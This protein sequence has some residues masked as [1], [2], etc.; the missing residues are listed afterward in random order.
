M[1]QQSSYNA[2]YDESNGLV[3]EG[4]YVAG[5]DANI[6]YYFNVNGGLYQ[7]IYQFTHDHANE[8]EFIRDYEEIREQL[9]EKYGEPSEDEEY[10]FDDLYKDDPSDWGMAIITGDL[11]YMTEW[12]TKDTT[13]RM[14]LEGDNYEQSFIIAYISNTVSNES[15]EKE[16]GL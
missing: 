10:W 1:A 11:A 12:N 6:Y 8:T 15:P 5:F 13:I 9:T 14:I 16:S 3:Y 4:A 7:S 2:F